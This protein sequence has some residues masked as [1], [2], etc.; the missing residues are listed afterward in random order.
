MKRRSAI[1][2]LS[3]IGART[4]PENWLEAADSLV[5][6]VH[7]SEK[8]TRCRSELPKIGV[9]T[10]TLPDAYIWHFGG[11]RNRM[12]ELNDY[13][14]R[15]SANSLPRS[16]KILER[17]VSSTVGVRLST[18]LPKEIRSALITALAL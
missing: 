13:H 10:E 3:K 12:V 11:I 8:A 16:T 6:L 7:N 15:N 1:S 2:D 14:G 9:S 5:L 18:N 17:A 4:V